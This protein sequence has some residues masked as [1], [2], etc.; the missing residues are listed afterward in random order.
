MPHAVALP[1]QHVYAMLSSNEYEPSPEMVAEIRSRLAGVC[2]GYSDSHIDSLV[3]EIA[4]VRIK[5]DRLKT[6]AFFVAA[7]ELAA[8]DRMMR[9]GA[10]ARGD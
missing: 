3:R 7:C 2:S 5:Y 10:P 4:Y 9:H 6:E 1:F 8:K